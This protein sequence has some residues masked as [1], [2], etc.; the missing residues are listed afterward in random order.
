LERRKCRREII[1]RS[2]RKVVVRG[3]EGSEGMPW[4]SAAGPKRDVAKI[5]KRG[6]RAPIRAARAK[7]GDEP[8]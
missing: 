6:L 8:V 4:N 5:G 2:W 1:E 7:G 3:V